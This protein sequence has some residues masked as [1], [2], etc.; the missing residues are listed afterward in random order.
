MATGAPDGYKR[1]QT[2]QKLY[3]PL[4]VYQVNGTV[5]AAGAT[6]T[7]PSS[8]YSTYIWVQN[9]SWDTLE[10]SLDGGTNYITCAGKSGFAVDARVQTF[11][12]RSAHASRSCAYNI[13]VG[14]E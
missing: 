11:K 9:N 10:I 13:I 14:Y 12:I 4:N 7:V 8:N 1:I 5:A 3:M 2:V 6:I